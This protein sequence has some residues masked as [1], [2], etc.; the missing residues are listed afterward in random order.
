MFLLQVFNK[1]ASVSTKNCKLNKQKRIPIINYFSKVRDVSKK[2]S[3]DV[4][5]I[6]LLR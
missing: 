6:T 3:S 5:E 1:K 2:E 4:T